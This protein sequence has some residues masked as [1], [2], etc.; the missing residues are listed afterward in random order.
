MYLEFYGLK[1]KPFTTRPDPRFLYLTPSHQEA[2]AQLA[3]G[4]QDDQG[5]VAL[6]GA[7]GT[8]KTTVLNAL[9]SQLNGTVAAAF[10]ANTMLPFEDL[11]E[12]ILEEF[13]TGLP[14]VS[15]VQRLVA[16]R[17]FLV[18][19]HQ[20][21]QKTVLILDEAQNLS[22]E[23]LEQVR[24]LS[25]FETADAKLLRILLVGQPELSAKLALPELAQLRQRIAFRFNIEP[26]TPEETHHCIRARLRIAGARDREIFTDRALD[27]IV[28]H[29]VGIPRVINILCDHCLLIGYAD[30]KRRI[31]WDVVEEAR[32]HLDEA[33][34][35]PVTPDKAPEKPVSGR[36]TLW[37]GRWSRTSSRA[38]ARHATGLSR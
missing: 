26:L 37:P 13:D 31:D 35:R 32:V 29:G 5:F 7:I 6:T 10:I 17:R 20:A 16:L 18:E 11:L 25:N 15:H 19:R 3:Y 22:A 28:F 34:P 21:G 14:D 9:R 2:L 12:L 36:W 33:A 24:L 23:T 27:R 30:Q 4:V 1:E 38:A 8:G